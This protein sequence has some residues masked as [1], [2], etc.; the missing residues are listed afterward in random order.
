MK[1]C[2]KSFFF[3]VCTRDRFAWRPALENIFLVDVDS[4]QKHANL[5]LNETQIFDIWDL[6]SPNLFLTASLIRDRSRHLLIHSGTFDIPLRRT[7]HD[8]KSQV[9]RSL[10]QHII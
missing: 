4:L 8:F 9:L 1:F 6:Q 2:I 10:I 5:T 7:R 3:D